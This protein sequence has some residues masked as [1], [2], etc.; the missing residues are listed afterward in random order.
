[1]KSDQGYVNVFLV[2]AFERWKKSNFS[3]WFSVQGMNSSPQLHVT[4]DNAT[5]EE[6]LPKRIQN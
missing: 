5:V 3:S 4:R 6:S 1:M 2:W